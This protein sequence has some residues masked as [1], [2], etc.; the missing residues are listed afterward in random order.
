MIVEISFTFVLRPLEKTCLKLN[1]NLW[2][3]HHLAVFG[4]QWSGASRDIKY[5]IFYMTSQKQMIE[6]SITLQVGAL[7][8]MSPPCQVCWPSYRSCGGMFLV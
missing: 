1:V 7:Y 2:V 5:L 3:S 8:G 6:G 4:G